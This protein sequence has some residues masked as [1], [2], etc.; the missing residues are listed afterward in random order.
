MP[1][2]KAP[3][4]WYG[5]KGRLADWII[6][7]FPPHDVYI[8]PFGGAASV[9]LAKQ[10][11][12]VE[13][14]NDLNSGVVNFYRCLRD[15]DKTAEL[16]RRLELTPYSREEFLHCRK[17]IYANEP[18]HYGDI[19]HAWNWA[20]CAMQCHSGNIAKGSPSWAI[21]AEVGNN[22][23]LRL[24]NDTAMISKISKRMENVCIENK[25]AFQLLESMDRTEMLC[26]LDPP[27]HEETG[28]TKYKHNAD[29]DKMISYCLS[30]KG[31]CLISGYGHDC[32]KPL[33]EEGWA[34]TSTEVWMSAANSRAYNN[35]Q[36][37]PRTESLYINP[38]CQAALKKSNRQIEVFT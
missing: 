27:Y 32:Y 15:A 22:K 16:Q 33:L 26:Y 36:L 5:G 13:I 14:Y 7:H 37:E 28:D 8:E 12:K 21:S 3:F 24:R 17:Y 2:L 10:P 23:A 34:T 18:A 6:S 35:G 11:C 9:L 31:L 1:K 29:Y 4:A 38:A 30:T 19:E 25:D 20:V